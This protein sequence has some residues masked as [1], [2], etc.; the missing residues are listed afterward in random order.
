MFFEHCCKVCIQLSIHIILYL[1]TADRFK[2]Q[3]TRH[4]K[5][6]MKNTIEFSLTIFFILASVLVKILREINELI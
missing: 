2:N 3:F 1:Q 4:S 5:I 6:P